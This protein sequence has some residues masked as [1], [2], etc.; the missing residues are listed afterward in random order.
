MG[1]IKTII[2]PLI[3]LSFI[4]MLHAKIVLASFFNTKYCDKPPFSVSQTR[5]RKLKCLSH[6]S[7]GEENDDKIKKIV[8]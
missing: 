4:I 1:K 2:S 3:S 7:E 5:L 8:T 6:G